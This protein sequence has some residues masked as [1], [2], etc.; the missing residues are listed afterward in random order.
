MTGDEGGDQVSYSTFDLKNL[1]W[2]QNIPVHFGF[3]MCLLSLVGFEV[4]GTLDAVL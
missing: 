1:G 4:F 2:D 3:G